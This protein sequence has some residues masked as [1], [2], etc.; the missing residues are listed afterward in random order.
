MMNALLVEHGL[1]QQGWRFNWM[2]R[3]H[4]YGLCRYG[5]KL[6]QLSI[7]FVDHNDAEKVLEVCRHEVAHALTPGA[8]HGWEWQ[9]IATQLGV[10]N[11][12]PCTSAAELPP[13]R[14]Q[15][16]CPSCSKLYSK[17]RPPK[18]GDGRF[19][20]CPPC[21]RK[22]GHLP[23]DE[24]KTTAELVYAD[25]L[26]SHVV[27]IPRTHERQ[28]VSAA[29]SAPSVSH[30]SPSADAPNAN[31]ETRSAPELARAMGIDPKKFRAWLRRWS[32]GPNYQVGP[33]GAYAFTAND[34]ADVVRAWKAT[35]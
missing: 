16:T 33:G 17:A 21:W 3:R 18:T 24:R 14:Y 35:H 13:A 20:Y 29:Q 9:M 25:S 8:K 30:Q 4:T 23:L 12:R 19:Y 11:P 10:V 1:F 31:V 6:V 7:L 27:S 5:P 26:A 15:A 2:D 32:L 34:I 22:T 28:P